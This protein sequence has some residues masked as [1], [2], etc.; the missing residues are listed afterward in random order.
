MF[1]IQQQERTQWPHAVISTNNE[2]PI[3]LDVDVV[4]SIKTAFHK[5]YMVKEGA[6]VHLILS[7]I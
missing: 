1:A 6:Q 7:A 2:R 3:I 4:T 5:V